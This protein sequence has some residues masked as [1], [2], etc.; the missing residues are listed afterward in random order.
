MIGGGSERFEPGVDRRHDDGD[1]DPG[2]LAVTICSIPP[3]RIGWPSSGR[4]AGSPKD[5]G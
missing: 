5:I 2:A 4:W 1:S 3:F